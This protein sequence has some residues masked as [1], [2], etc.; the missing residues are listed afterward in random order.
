MEDVPPTEEGSAGLD[1]GIVAIVVVL[2]VGLMMYKSVF[3]VHEREV[4]VLQRLGRKL[5]KLTAGWHFVIPWIDAPRTYSW[6][7][8]KASTSGRLELIN[9]T[10]RKKISTKTESMD[11]PKQDVISRDNA[12]ITLDAILNYRIADPVTMIY[13]T[14]NLPYMLS[15]LLQA[16]IRNAAG[17]LDVDKIVDDTT[18]LSGIQASLNNVT[19][20]WGVTIEKVGVQEV[21]TH[22]LR[23]ALAKRKTAELNNK[24]VIIKAKTDK[25]TTIV[26]AEG[27][28]D[29]LIRVAEGQSQQTVSR[30]RGEAQAIINRANAEARS[31]QEIARVVSASGE[32]PTSYLLAVKYIDVF[33]KI[34]LYQN[35]SV[36][37][38][39]KQAA[40]LL[41]SK[42]LGLS[43]IAGNRAK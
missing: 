11:F 35:T 1:G 8:Y 36:E 40:F 42:G 39:P 14:Q 33:G 26:R 16:Q 17:T 25:Q 22:D 27:K 21:D 7:Y 2:V 38:L 24:E 37:F 12:R 13:S 6:R 30:A 4:I 9:F 29:E 28:R 18:V 19:S 31:V 32:D 34:L 43:T 5:G 10:G 23:S 20:K 3:V 41:T 15:K